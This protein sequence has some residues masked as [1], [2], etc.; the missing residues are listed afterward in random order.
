MNL[1]LELPFLIVSRQELEARVARQA[2]EACEHIIAEMGAELHDDL[3]QKLSVFTL[4]MDR[5]ERSAG[6]RSEAESL[7][8]KMRAEFQEVVRSIRSTSRRLMAPVLDGASFTQNLSLLCQNLERPGVGNIHFTSSG[9]EHSISPIAHRYLSRIIQ[10]LVH[11]AYRHSSA[12]N[13]YINVLWTADTLTL[14]VEDDGSALNRVNEFIDV[15]RKKN[16][17]LRLRAQALNANIRYI[18]GAKGLIAE[19]KYPL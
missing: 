13:I 4:Y 19:V 3:I 14:T 5:L 12:W 6:D 9:T 16:N 1:P 8:V 15:L 7:V 18:P 10:E 11:N 17:T 2:L